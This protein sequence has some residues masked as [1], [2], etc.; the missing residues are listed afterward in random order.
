MHSEMVENE[1]HLSSLQIQYSQGKRT[2]V[3]ESEGRTYQV[4]TGYFNSYCLI[5]IYSF[6]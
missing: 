1:C 5:C 2:S 6:K 3:T 4:L